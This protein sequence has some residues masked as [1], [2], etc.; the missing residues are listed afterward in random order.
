VFFFRQYYQDA[1]EIQ[2]GG[3]MLCARKMLFALLYSIIYVS[4]GFCYSYTL[5]GT[6]YIHGLK[7]VLRIE[8]YREPNETHRTDHG[9][10]TVTYP[11]GQLAIQGQNVHNVKTGDWKAWYPDGTLESVERY[12]NSKRNGLSVYY[13]ENGTKNTE[14]EWKDD[15]R[16]GKYLEW[17]DNNQIARQG[18]Y[19]NGQMC[20]H[21]RFWTNDGRELSPSDYGPCSFGNIWQEESQKQGI[22]VTVKADKTRLK[23]APHDPCKTRVVLTVTEEIKEGDRVVEQPV[24]GIEIAL[25]RPEYGTLSALKT[26]TNSNGMAEVTF[27]APGDELF[28]QSGKAEVTIYVRATEQKTFHK[29]YEVIKIESQKKALELTNERTI[30][31]AYPGYYSRVQFTFMAPDKKDGGS[32]EVILRARDPSGALTKTYGDKGTNVQKLS[33]KP[34]RDYTYF[35][36]W[37]GPDE[38]ASAVNEAVIVEIP[39]LALSQ[40]VSLSVGIDPGIESVQRKSGGP[41]SPFIFEPFNVYVTDFFH[42]KEDLAALLGAL[43]IKPSV[44]IELASYVPPPIYNPK[45]KE[46]FSNLLDHFQGRIADRN[47]L[48]SE[49]EVCDLKK[50]GSRYI[51]FQYSLADRRLWYPGVSMWERGSYQFKVMANFGAVDSR[52][53]NNCMHT[54][55]LQVT[56]YSGMMEETMHTILIPTMKFAFTLAGGVVGKVTATLL[57]SLDVSER[58]HKGDYQ[59]AFVGS[60]GMIAG[61]IAGMPAD[62]LKELIARSRGIATSAVTASMMNTVKN[63]ADLNTV[64]ALGANIAELVGPSGQSHYERPGIENMIMPMLHAAGGAGKTDIMRLMLKG[65]KDYYLVVIDKKGISNYT[66][67]KQGR[68]KLTAVSQGIFSADGPGQVMVD[69][70]AYVTIPVRLGEKLRLDLSGSGASGAVRFITPYTQIVYEYPRNSWQSTLSIDG[71][72]SVQYHGDKLISASRVMSQ[73]DILYRQGEVYMNR[74]AGF[75]S[76]KII[77]PVITFHVQA[78]GLGRKAIDIIQGKTTIQAYLEQVPS[79]GRVTGCSIVDRSKQPSRYQ[80]DPEGFIVHWMALGPFAGPRHG[81]MSAAWNTDFL[82]PFGGEAT[83]RLTSGDGVK[84]SFSKEKGI[85]TDPPIGT[86]NL[87]PKKVFAEGCN[88][89]LGNNF[90]PNQFVCAYAWCEIESPVDRQCRILYGCDDALRIILNGQTIAD[91]YTEHAIVRDQYEVAGNLKKGSN[92]LLV[93]CTQSEGG[94]LFCVRVVDTSYQPLTDCQIVLK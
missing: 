45:E 13:H 22:L 43:L 83:A 26:T 74:A 19:D 60:L 89:N 3:F 63:T 61:E 15:V 11:N 73:S 64:A 52:L 41:M 58:M 82:E 24:S 71:I 53:A 68:V 93:K 18:A 35:Y 70:G 79:D 62:K 81:G 28:T 50:E 86:K 38:L 5:E 72:G 85:W 66:A 75:V 49:I 17:Y 91:S 55:P 39:E 7:C 54:S 1:Q 30:L 42:P 92:F 12:A 46:F 80:F 10:Y 6:T 88:I 21:W 36:H 59:G 57:N 67:Y 25:E 76:D 27:E 48:V 20:G 4:F 40:E 23:T 65:F 16:H 56:E 9:A 44:T 8:C 94:W 90:R 47:Y 34:R 84:Y 32:Y 14:I 69:E 29:D 87:F 78:F 33:C 2:K 37:I 77:E 51:L 31:P